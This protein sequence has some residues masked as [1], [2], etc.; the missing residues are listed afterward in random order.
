MFDYHY[1]IIIL[2]LLSGVPFILRFLSGVS[3]LGVRE[4]INSALS[5]TLVE[6]FPAQAEGWQGELKK[7]FVMA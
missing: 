1:I 4:V 6:Y 7:Y 5:V 2:T 3:H